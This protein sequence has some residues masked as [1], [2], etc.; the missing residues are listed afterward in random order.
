MRRAYLDHNATTPLRPEARARWLE[1]ADALGGNPSSLHAEGRR[2]RDVL[3]RARE[4]A[5][6]AL[7][8]H[9][10]EIVFT[11]GATEANNLAL[12][13]ALAC[14]PGGALVVSAIE[15]SSVLE[16]ARALHAAGHPLRALPVDAEG[17]LEPRALR[18]A[19][20]QPALS[21]VSLH[22]ANNEIGVVYDPPDVAE[23][24]RSTASGRVLLHV[25]AAQALGRLPVDLARWGADL[26]SFSAHKVGG[27]VGCGIL[28]RRRG[29]RLVPLAT[30]GVHEGGLRAGTEDVAGIAAAAVAIELAAREQPAFAARTSALVRELWHELCVSVP[31]AVLLG[32]PLGSR[33]RLPNTLAFRVPHEDGKVLVTR[34]DLE[35]VAIGAG[36]ACASG[37]LEPSHVLLALGCDEDEARAGLRVSLGRTTTRDECRLALDAFR[38]QLARAS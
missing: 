31:H 9:E 5:A 36:S 6:A 33:E 8:A 23:V 1:V 18:D 12:R 26:V 29:T 34:L 13:G 30:G 38:K 22:A 24:V 7:G 37:A 32:P 27:P 28:W 21:L 10:D 35:G 4:Q 14:A 15:H 3:D 20:A 25:D 11:S 17:R 19:L 2:A 16:T